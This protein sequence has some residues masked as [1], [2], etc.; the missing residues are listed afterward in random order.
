M[1]TTTLLDHGLCERLDRS[2]STVSGNANIVFIAQV[3]FDKNF[4]A[5]ANSGVLASAL[6]VNAKSFS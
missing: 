4:L 1:L 5:S 6:L 3:F 2:S